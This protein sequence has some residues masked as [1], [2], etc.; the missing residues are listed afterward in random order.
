MP[1]S[2][3]IELA[4]LAGGCFWCIEAAL[5]RLEG[6]CGVVSGYTGGHVAEPDYEVVCSG[7]S[8]HAEAVQ[9]AFDPGVLG[10]RDLLEVFF[11]LHDPTTRN[12]QGGDVGTQYRSAVFFHSAEQEAIVR[13]LV[14]ELARE[15][16]FG[17]PIVTQIEAAGPFHPAEPHHQG[18]YRNHPYQPYCRFVVAPKLAKLHEKFRSR[19]KRPTG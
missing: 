2:R 13:G 1:A 12:R 17:A 8:G 10:Y 19:L 5:E 18:Y 15:D 9:V 4:T 6:V 14:V 3:G 16:A 11:A 7:E